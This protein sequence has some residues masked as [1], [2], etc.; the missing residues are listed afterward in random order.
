MAVADGQVA[1]DAGEVTAAHRLFRQRRRL[2]VFS[3]Y[4]EGGVCGWTFCGVRLLV[5]VWGGWGRD[6]GHFGCLLMIKGCRGRVR[7][8]VWGVGR[9][10]KVSVVGANNINVL[11]IGVA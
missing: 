1:V 8:R 5:C 10:G 9:S 6:G 7:G 3:A 2:R 4:S 11:K